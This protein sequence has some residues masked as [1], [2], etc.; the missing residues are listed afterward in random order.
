MKEG[1]LTRDVVTEKRKDP[2]RVLNEAW[3]A[4]PRMM[5]PKEAATYLGITLKVLMRLRNEGR[6]P[7]HVFGICTVRERVRYAI[8]DVEKF[9]ESELSC[10]E[11][12]VYVAGF[13]PYVK[14]GFSRTPKRR[15]IDLQVAAPERLTLYATL[16]ANLWM[17]AELHQDFAAYRTCGEWFRKEGA[18]AEWIEKGCPR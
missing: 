9:L 13:G 1:P 6:L 17:E 12:Y 16:R 10:T 4:V 2:T 5:T 14:I 15:V 8:K 11:G 7:Y 18:L 3:A